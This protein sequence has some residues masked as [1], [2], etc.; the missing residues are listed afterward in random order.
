VHV[1][2]DLNWPTGPALPPVVGGTVTVTLADF[3]ALSDVAGSVVGRPP[4]LADTLILVRTDASTVV[5]RS[6]I[7]THAGC[8]IAYDGQ[9]NDF[10][11]GCHGST[12]AL[13]GTVTLGPATKPLKQYPSTFD[14]QT[15]VVT[16][17]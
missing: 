8:K 10:N 7:C 6:A 4:G 12:F 5:A 2:I 1:F 11:C 16:V 3:P 13:D 15:V 14:G 17:A 9:V